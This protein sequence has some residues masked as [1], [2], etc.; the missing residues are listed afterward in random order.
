[1][2]NEFICAALALFESAS[3]QMLET[4]MVQK[5]WE[6]VDLDLDF[7]LS[8]VQLDCGTIA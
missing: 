6:I 4:S 7:P 1:M 5:G 8:N 2:M 3:W